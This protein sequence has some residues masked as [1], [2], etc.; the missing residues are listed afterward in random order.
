MPV[1]YFI[2]FDQGERPL[3]GICGKTLP[4]MVVSGHICAVIKIN[5]F[6]MTDREVHSGGD[7]EQ[8]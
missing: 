5:E 1:R 8:K 4:C 6:M 3:D 7:D 2:G